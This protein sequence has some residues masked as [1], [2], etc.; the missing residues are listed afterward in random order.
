M[1]MDEQEQLLVE[2]IPYKLAAIDLC[3]YATMLL[4]RRSGPHATTIR[5][6]GVGEIWL[7]DMS[8]FT[9]GVVEHG[10]M[11][12]RAMLEFLGIGL[13]RAQTRLEEYRRHRADTATLKHF[14]LDLLTVKDVTRHL[15]S[16]NV[17]LDGLVQTI[18]AAHK[19][20]AHLTIG[21][22]KLKAD[23]LAAGCRATRRL[24]DHFLYERLGRAAPAVRLA[25]DGANAI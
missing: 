17:L 9:N 7:S 2:H 19:G 21:G 20:G 16:D 4:G 25:V 3:R 6:D 24:V 8:V 11:S 18:R 22:E 10:F 14:N 15:G 23:P 5:I 1:T 13:D 12:C